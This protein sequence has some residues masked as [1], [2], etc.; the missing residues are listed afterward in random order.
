MFPAYNLFPEIWSCHARDILAFYGLTWHPAHPI[1]SLWEGKLARAVF[2]GR[3]TVAQSEM[4]ARGHQVPRAVRCFSSL[5]FHL[6]T[7]PWDCRTV[8]VIEWECPAFHRGGRFPGCTER[9]LLRVKLRVWVWVI[10]QVGEAAMA[11]SS[12]H[13]RRTPALQA[14]SL[15][16]LVIFH[17][18]RKSILP[19]TYLSS[20]HQKLLLFSSI[21]EECN[22]SLII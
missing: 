13:A 9:V 16:C 17:V 5:F 2:R 22:L 7:R 8:S 21:W 12:P 1:A 10:H 14:R 19:C 18:P 4:F 20:K 11:S 6:W 3:A 15:G